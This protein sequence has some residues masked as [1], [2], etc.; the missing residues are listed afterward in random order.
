MQFAV[1]VFIAV[2][3]ACG[4][5]GIAEAASFRLYP[6]IVCAAAAC[7][8]SKARQNYSN[9]IRIIKNL[10]YAVLLTGI[11]YLLIELLVSTFYLLFRKD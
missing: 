3:C 10:L 9:L 8:M 2:L 6:S 1:S 11:V 5:G 7:L 4:G